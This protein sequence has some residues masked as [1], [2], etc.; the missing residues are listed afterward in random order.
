MLASPEPV[1]LSHAFPPGL[2]YLTPAVARSLF[3]F[4]ADM[5]PVPVEVNRLNNQILV[6]Y[7][8]EGWE[9]YADGRPMTHP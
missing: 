4:P 7:H 6:R 2:R 1:T 8:A 3:E 5:A 9:R